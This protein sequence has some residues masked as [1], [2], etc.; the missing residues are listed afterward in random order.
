MYTQKNIISSGNCKFKLGSLDIWIV[1][2]GES[3]IAPIQPMFAPNI[4]PKQVTDLLEQH[5]LATDKITLAGNILLVKSNGKTILIDTGCGLQLSPT[6]GRL[7]ENLQEAGIS[8]EEIT[9]II[10]TH[11]HPDHIGGL[12]DVSG[13]LTFPNAQIYISKI[14]FDYWMAEEPDFTKGTKNEI[15]DFEVMFAKQIFNSIHSNFH[16]FEDGEILFDCLKLEIAPGHTPGHAILT[17]FS[18]NEELVHIADTFQHILLLEHPEWGNQ[19]DSDFN[20]AIETRTR[21]SEQLVVSKKLVFADHLPFP[22]LGFIKKT[23]KIYQWVPLTYYTT[24]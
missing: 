15:A 3:I 24:H 6:T 17:I 20:L 19:I 10:L 18:D 21:I 23:G 8:Q 13:K 14:E 9:D 1:T 11:A 2:D 22:G 12:T 7:V 16:F 5:F 4:E